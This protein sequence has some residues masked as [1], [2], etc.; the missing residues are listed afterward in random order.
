MSTEDPGLGAGR[1]ATASVG[2]DTPLEPEVR[3]RRNRAFGA[4]VEVGSGLGLDTSGAR[5]LQDWNDTIVHLA[6]EPVVARVRTSWA[7]AVEPGEVT[8]ARELAVVRHAA[9]RGAPVVPPAEP[10]GPFIQDGLAITL[11]RYAEELPEETSDA[12]AGR[13]LLELHRALADFDAVLPSLSERLERASSVISAPAAVPRLAPHDRA[14]LEERFAALRADADS[15]GRAPRVLHGGPH[16][17]NLLATREGPRWI[18]FDTTCRG[19]LEWDLAHLG[20]DAAALFPDS[21]AGLLATMRN[22]VSADVAI[23]CWHTYGRAPEVDEAARYHLEAL[24]D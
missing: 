13:A 14:F 2:A 20:H 11:W 4:A 5:I 7:E 24:R 22:L 18:D 21:D 16:T 3:A 1:Y 10:A 12:E 8:Q 6:P 23:W 17:A 15:G 9:A 19:P